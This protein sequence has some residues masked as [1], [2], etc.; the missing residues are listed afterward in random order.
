MTS[1]I[2]MLTNTWKLDEDNDFVQDPPEDSKDGLTEDEDEDDSEED[3][4]TKDG[5]SDETKEDVLN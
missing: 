5:E 3:N 2:P 4:D 1:L